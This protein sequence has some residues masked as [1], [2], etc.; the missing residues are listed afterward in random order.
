MDNIL[1]KILQSIEKFGDKDLADGI[2]KILNRKKP[3][4]RATMDLIISLL[5]TLENFG[6]ELIIVF[7]NIDGK[8]FREL[9]QHELL[10]ELAAHKN[11]LVPVVKFK[12]LGEI[13]SKFQ[14]LQ[15]SS[16][17]FKEGADGLQLLLHS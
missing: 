10:S 9:E 6:E 17:S 15:F 11:V 16:T 3:E 7:H 8:H 2:E 13:Y 14:P 4:Q 1:V 12:I 5:G